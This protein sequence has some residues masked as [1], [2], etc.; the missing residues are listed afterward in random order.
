MPTIFVLLP[1]YPEF[2]IS[3]GSLKK[4]IDKTE[5]K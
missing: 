3:H 4:G 2:T 5:S 1:Y